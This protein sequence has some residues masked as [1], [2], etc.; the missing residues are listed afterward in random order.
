MDK[1]V[2]NI[3]KVEFVKISDVAEYRQAP[4]GSVVITAPWTEVRFSKSPSLSINPEYNKAGRLYNVS[5]TALLESKLINKN[6]L[7]VRVSFDDGSRPMIIGDPDLPVRFLE[8]HD[9]RSKI[10]N[11]QHSSWHYPFREADI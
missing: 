9:L 11:F 5:F 4:T 6:L 2:N 1:K 7:L 8:S 10:L 3:C